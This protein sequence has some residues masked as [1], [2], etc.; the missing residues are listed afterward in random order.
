MELVDDL[1]FEGLKVFLCYAV[2]FNPHCV[3][4]F[5][6]TSPPEQYSVKVSQIT[7]SVKK[8]RGSSSC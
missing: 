7:D 3:L 4:A 6:S 2:S 8:I 5:H 1:I